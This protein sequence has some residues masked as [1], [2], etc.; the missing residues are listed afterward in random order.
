MLLA[1]RLTASDFLEIVRAHSIN[2]YAS[3]HFAACAIREGKS[4]YD[5]VVL[6]RLAA[7]SGLGVHPYLYPPLLADA[8]TPMTFL[9]V[10]P[11]RLVWGGLN[12]AAFAL[13]FFL[14]DRWL[15][16]SADPENAGGVRALFA[17][18]M[19]VFWPIR[20]SQW[21]AQVN[22]IVLLLI[23][24]WWTRRERSRWS[25]VWLGIA[26]AIKMSPALLL[27]YIVARRAWR[28]AAI[29]A[30]VA[31][32]LVVVPCM[33]LGH[34]GLD[35]V[36]T[37]GGF[38][39][40]HRWHALTVPIDLFG[41]HSLAALAFAITG[42]GGEHFRLLAPAAR[43]HVAF[44][45]GLFVLWA[46]RSR[47][48]PGDASL[49]A[50]VVL[51]VIAP[52]YTYEHHLALAAISIAIALR[53]LPAGRLRIVRAFLVLLCLCVLSDHIDAFLPPPKGVPQGLLAALWRLPK[54]YPMLIL[55]TILVASIS[56]EEQT[57]MVASPIPSVA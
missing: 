8:L 16:K 4:P 39:P 33:L 36:G 2:D 47:K 3:F 57:T 30:A 17:V 49:G 15:A 50:L 52:T 9:D 10:W 22:A 14:L 13:S 55:F 56:R 53:A 23:V 43:L 35:F 5:I 20:Q 7:E 19:A 26:I 34:R 32:V 44:V 6:Q 31:T 42:N 25:G 38:L 29:V 46:W 12:V 21:L 45:A 41:N 28:E 11:A 18:A 1:A 27:A 37:A 48:R 51:M 24:L 54:L 40:G